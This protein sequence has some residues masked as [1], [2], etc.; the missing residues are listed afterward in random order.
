M[1]S[2]LYAIIPPCKKCPYT[3]GFV[4]CVANP[5]PEC[6]MN[7]YRSFDEFIKMMK[8][9]PSINVMEDFHRK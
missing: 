5:C 8:K 6:K 4:K 9:Q 1:K 7:K 2:L 3:L